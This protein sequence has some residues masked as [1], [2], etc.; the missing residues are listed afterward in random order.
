[1]ISSQPYD[2]SSF[3][4]MHSFSLCDAYQVE[5]VKKAEQQ[6]KRLAVPEGQ[7]ITNFAPAQVTLD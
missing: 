1:M 5:F 4:C 3:A 2:Q 7:P 6:Q